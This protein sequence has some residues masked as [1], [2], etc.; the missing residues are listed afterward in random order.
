MWLV[1]RGRR[2]RR[3]RRPG[4]GQGSRHDAGVLSVGAV[5]AGTAHQ[6]EQIVDCRCRARSCCGE[7][8]G[9][10]REGRGR[11]VAWPLRLGHASSRDLRLAGS[12]LTH[13][14]AAPP[15]AGV[16]LAGGAAD[17]TPGTWGGAGV[18]G[19][20]GAVPPPL[21]MAGGV[22]GVPLVAVVAP[23]M[24]GALGVPELAVPW[25]A[26]PLVAGVAGLV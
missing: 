10:C 18:A 19:V 1:S 4:S 21:V 25:L 6:H 16:A 23:P 9:W 17:V 24:A 7:M 3:R 12:S 13:D 11:G 8:S 5:R 14:P 26:G 22:A 20:A 2:C 15:G